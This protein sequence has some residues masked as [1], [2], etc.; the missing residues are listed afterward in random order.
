MSTGA[1]RD[2]PWLPGFI[3]AAALAIALHVAAANTPPAETAWGLPQLM[4][5]M[6]GVRTASARFVEKKFVQ[7][8]ARPL[9]SSGTLIFNAPDRLQKETLAPTASRLTVN[10]DRLTVVQP[11]GKTRDMSLSEVPEIGALVESIRA[12]LAGD[13]ATLTR[14][15]APTLSGTASNWSLTLEPRNSRLR[16]L[17]TTIHMQGE[18]TII[19]SIETVEHDGD[20]TEM[21]ITPDPR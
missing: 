3:A 10:G 4:A 1:S 13:G 2:R 11:D 12:T 18:G 8:L 19:R 20:R 14:Y 21:T 5:S 6:H 9:Q 15:Y 17:V 7:L 16:D